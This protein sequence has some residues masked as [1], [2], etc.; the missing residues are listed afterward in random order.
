M[1]KTKL[2]QL[3]TNSLMASLIFVLPSNLFFVLTRQGSYVNGI[4]IDYLL[5]KLYLSDLLLITLS[6]WLWFTGTIKFKRIF[7]F[8]RTNKLLF[9][10]GTIIVTRQF[11]TAAPL[12]AIWQTIKLLEAVWF[13]FLLDQIW[14]KINKTWLISSASLSLFFQSGL[15]LLQLFNQQSIAGYW[16]FGEPNLN[17]QIGLAKQVLLGQNLVLPYGTTAH[18][19]VLA[20]FISLSLLAFFISWRSRLL[21]KY[22]I[23]ILTASTVTG[24]ICLW[25]TQSWSAITTLIWGIIF[26][27]FFS[28]KKMQSRLLLAIFFISIA[29]TLILGQQTQQTSTYRRGYL[30]EA[31]LKMLSANPIFGQGINN[32]VYHVETFSPTREIVRFV[33]PAHHVPVL[34]IAEW[35][36]LGLF[37]LYLIWKKIDIENK[38]VIL[39][40]STILLPILVLDHYLYTLQAGLLLTAFFFVLIKNSSTQLQK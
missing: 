13:C 33:Q 36:I 7:A 18:P 28:T 31:G 9:L 20:G 4:S 34:F 26:L 17:N 22:Q 5:P 15:G 1:N 32:F 14:A 12:G 16:L 30:L 37:F 2:H 6:I 35:G 10:L 3:I 24:V 8:I 39:K 21:N 25:F 40:T 27:K 29:V 11:F 19:N 38:A 23:G